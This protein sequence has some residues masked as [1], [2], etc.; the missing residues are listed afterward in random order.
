MRRLSALFFASF[1]FAFLASPLRAETE[2]VVSDTGTETSETDAAH[3]AISTT[4]DA[5]DATTAGLS[6]SIE[7]PIEASPA[8]SAATPAM[9]TTEAAAPAETEI[10]GQIVAL[11]G[12]NNEIV[13]KDKA[14]N[15]DRRITV[16]PGV[17]S[18]AAL[19]VGDSVRVRLSA[20]AMN[21]GRAVSIAAD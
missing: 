2:V 19:S 20:D 11:D 8:P 21:A 4:A 7:N 12:A 18:S 17:M 13:V 15:A 10:N 16:D 5:S 14:T 6:S 9:T 3:S 1:A